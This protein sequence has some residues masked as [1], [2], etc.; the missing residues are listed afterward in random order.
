M[1]IQLLYFIATVGILIRFGKDLASTNYIYSYLQSLVIYTNNYT[2][3][4]D[5]YLSEHNFEMQSTINI[6]YRKI[7]N[8][9]EKFKSSKL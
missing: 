3:K 1:L 5:T 6:I 8:N 7:S 2:T 9:I 4:H